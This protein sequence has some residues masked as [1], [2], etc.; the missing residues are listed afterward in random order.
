MIAGQHLVGVV[1]QGM[2]AADNIGYMV[3]A[4]V[5]QHVLRDIEDG[6][7]FFAAL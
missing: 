3:P 5:V 4:P 1:M 7:A 2:D 6:R